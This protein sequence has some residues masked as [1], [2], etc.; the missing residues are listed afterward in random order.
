[1]QFKITS[2]QIRTMSM[3]NLSNYDSHLIVS[4]LGYDPKTISVISN[5]EKS[6]FHFKNM[7]TTI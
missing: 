1:M 6:I 7:L 5:N 4:E 2:P 3:H